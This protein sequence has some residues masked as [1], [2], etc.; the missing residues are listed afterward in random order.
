MTFGKQVTD[1]LF[2]LQLPFSPPRN[3]A[4]LDVHQHPDVQRSFTDF[5]AKFY[6]D[7]QKRY[8][9]VGINPGRFGGGITGIPFTDPV[10]LQEDCGIPNPFPK[11]QELSSAFIY[12]MIAAYGGPDAFYR[13]FY[14]TAVSPLGFTGNGKNLNYYDDPV[15]LRRIEPFV[16]DCM[17]RQLQFG[18]KRSVCFCIG[19]GD[20]LKHLERLNKQHQWFDNIVG[21]PHPRFIM[22]YKRRQIASYIQRYVEQLRSATAA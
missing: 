19:E 3:I 2:T 1:F 5:Y 17:E 9:L 21:L 10:R 14:I 16:V 18:A 22:Q 6:N 11:K 8:L 20:N 12:N 13:K 7:Q 15:L 4:V